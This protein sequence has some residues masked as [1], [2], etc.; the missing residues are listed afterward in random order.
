MLLL[1]PISCAS[2]P[3]A[4]ISSLPLLLLRHVPLK[5]Q[6]SL[7][8]WWPWLWSNPNANTHQKWI[9]YSLST[10][11][12]R[13][14]QHNAYIHDNPVPRIVERCSTR[15]LLLH[16]VY[17]MNVYL[18]SVF[19]LLILAPLPPSPTLVKAK[20]KHTTP[21]SNTSTDPLDTLW[22]V[23]LQGTMKSRIPLID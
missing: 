2:Q 1:Q 14:D 19:Q 9:F 4:I 7:I 21:T 8:S 18:L 12:V 3:Q 16:L 17:P 6:Q 13:L 10:T 15:I 23:C 5:H 20:W 11:K 22:S